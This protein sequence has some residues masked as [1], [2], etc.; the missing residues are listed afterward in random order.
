MPQIA[1]LQNGSDDYTAFYRGIGY[2]RGLKSIIKFDVQRMSQLDT[3][4]SGYD[5]TAQLISQDPTQANNLLDSF[6]KQYISQ[7][8]TI[9]DSY[10]LSIQID[11][12]FSL[13]GTLLATEPNGKIAS[14]FDNLTNIYGRALYIW[15]D[16]F[17]RLFASVPAFGG[18]QQTT[19]LTSNQ[20][21]GV[22][23]AGT[24]F[25]ALD[26]FFFTKNSS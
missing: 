18:I 14:Q 17:I 3:L 2:L 19:Q 16:N 9:L 8:K 5:R 21:I 24:G 25:G 6:R 23:G 4:L 20:Q 12:D 11:K 15:G 26:G 13:Q 1:K 7:F 10:S 22:A